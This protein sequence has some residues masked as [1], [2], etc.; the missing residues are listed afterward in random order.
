MG[1]ENWMRAADWDR[2][3]TVEILRH[4]Y[5]EGRLNSEELDERT[6]AAF[7]ARTIGDL[8]R[9]IADLLPHSSVACLP[10]DRPEL[11]VIPGSPRRKTG[12]SARVRLLILLAAL[13]CISIGAATSNAAVMALVVLAGLVALTRAGDE[14]RAGPRL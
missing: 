10:S 14:R 8:R 6:D 4:S 11:P 3:E 1:A 12:Y 2:E 9:L 13:A 7:N 5:V